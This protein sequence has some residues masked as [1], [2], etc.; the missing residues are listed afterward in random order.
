MAT[1]YTHSSKNIGLSWLYLSIFLV[2]VISIGYVFGAIYGSS[3]ILYFAVAF[4]VIT[5]FASYWWSDK[6]VLSMS[7]AKLVEREHHPEW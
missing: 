5:S 4:S 1:A 6:I 7:H 2:V 3:T